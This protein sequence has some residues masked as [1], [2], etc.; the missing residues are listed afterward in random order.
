MPFELTPFG[1][2]HLADVFALWRASDGLGLFGDTHERVS[3]CLR[4]SPGMSFVALRG[5]ALA[6]A[7]LCTHDG[8]RGYLHHLAVAPDCRRQGIGRALAESCAAALEA[9]GIPKCHLFVMRTNPGALAFWAG[10]GWVERDDIVMMSRT[11]D[12]AGSR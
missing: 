12:S 9:Q 8:R 6:G 11:L 3:D 2:E 5:G 10:I 4:R 1:P 7:V